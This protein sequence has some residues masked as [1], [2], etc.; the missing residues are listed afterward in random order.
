MCTRSSCAPPATWLK[1]STRTDQSP[2]FGV[3]GPPELHNLLAR[4]DEQVLALQFPPKS[5]KSA[6]C[7]PA[8]S[9]RRASRAGVLSGIKIHIEKR[10]WRCAKPD[11]LLDDG[12]HIASYTYRQSSVLRGPRAGDP[13]C[14]SSFACRC[15]KFWRCAAG[16]E[17]ARARARPRIRA[18][19]L[20]PDCW[21]AGESS[22]HRAF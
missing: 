2:F 19:G 10:L 20:C 14:A 21:R 6:R 15:G 7:F 11:A 4:N 9:G 16:K 3:S 22:W 13:S 8:D 5:R 18:A 12:S 1:V 17:R